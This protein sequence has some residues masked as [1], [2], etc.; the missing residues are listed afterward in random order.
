MDEKR[1]EDLLEIEDKKL[2][3]EIIKDLETFMEF[4]P[5]PSK[6]LI[7]TKNREFEGTLLL[8]EETGIEGYINNEKS[9]FVSYSK[10]RENII[11]GLSW[12]L[13]HNPN[14]YGDYC[15]PYSVRRRLISVLE[16]FVVL[17]EVED[18]KG[19]SH[20]QRVTGLFL[21]F[22]SYLGIP[23]FRKKLFLHYS[24]L[25]DVGRIGLEQL[26]LYSP[27][28]LRIFEQ[29]G[30]DHTVTGSVYISTLE[31]LNDFIPFVRSHHER[32]DGN[33]FPDGLK[34]DE[35]PYWVRVLSITNWYDNALNTVD[36]EF[37]TGVLNPKEAKK[38][39]LGDNGL[40]FDPQ[41]SKKFVEFLNER[42]YGFSKLG[43]TDE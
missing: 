9:F 20:S 34:G 22:C 14:S 11:L 15:S 27:T 37:S 5:Y 35:I 19:Y 32:F 41:I 42:E 29:N 16:P 25:H 30:Q 1:L 28:R 23:E 24:M 21:D 2:E 17:M 7:T 38:Y 6:S 10:K 36:S 12:I 43:P 4:M 13:G 33:G 26:M 18:K 8:I 39:I 3:E 40:L 31:V